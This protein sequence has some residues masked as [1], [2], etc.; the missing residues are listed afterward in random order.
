VVQWQGPYHQP[1]LQDLLA[2][3]AENCRLRA[4]PRRERLEQEIDHLQQAL[5]EQVKSEAD[6]LQTAKLESLAEFA[7]GA[8]HEINNPLAVISGQA[9]Y[10]LGHDVSW[11][12]D[13][14][15]PEVKKSLQAIIAQTRRVHG[16]LRDLM[17]FA[18]PPAANP[19]VV[20]LPTLLAETVAGVKDLAEQRRV[21]VELQLPTDR[22][23][24]TLDAEQVRQAL[25]CLVRNGIEAAAPSGVR[26]QESGV[27]SQESGVSKDPLILTPDSCFLTPDSK[28]GW[29]R[30]ALRPPVPGQLLEV[31]V[32]DSG[33]G[34]DALIKPHLFDPFFS[35]RNAG[36]GKGLG[37]PIAWRLARLQGGEV[38]LAPAC[39]GQ[40]T[41]FV[42]RL[43]GPA[44][45]SG[46]RAAA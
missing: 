32:E 12:A 16:L 7:A 40:P 33:P 31:V 30:I 8:G 45:I 22:L 11:F 25:S 38:F 20:D 9:Q 24:V 15:Q 34:P 39:P 2:V 13:H 14:A 44:E 41:R 26:S 43:P 6:R 29:V 4:G 46:Q 10:L 3:A 27:R 37:L 36:R 21:R 18:R 17:Q 23:A 19:M 1:L 42:L 28:E 35:G 5:Q